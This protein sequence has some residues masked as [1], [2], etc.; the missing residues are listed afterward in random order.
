MSDDSI[1]S[2]FPL[3]FPWDT[4]DPFL[5]CVH[6][7]DFYPRGN[8]QFGPNGSLQ[9]R[10]LGQDFTIKDGW[11]M[12][13]GHKVPG[14]PVHPHRGFETVTIVR[15]GYVDHSDSLGAA[16]RYGEGDLQWLTTGHG[17]QHSEM[18]PLLHQ[19]NE[20]T[21]DLFQIWLNLPAQKKMVDPHF[22]MIWTETI[23]RYQSVDEQG[24][25]IEVIVYAGHLHDIQ[26]VDPTPE[27]WAADKNN[28]VAIWIIKLPAQST[29]VL[30][31]ATDQLNRTLYFY[32]GTEI[33]IDTQPI[34][35]QH[36][37]RLQSNKKIKIIN[38]GNDAELL[39]LQGRPINQPV[40]QYGPFVMNTQEEIHQAISDY[41]RSQFGGWPWPV[42]DPVHGDLNQGRFAKHS[43]GNL[44]KPPISNDSS[45][46]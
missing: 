30:P 38:S 31:E 5:F 39:L 14:F 33:E 45:V 18:F 42:P 35:P 4:F 43:D 24:N 23:P 1:I 16:G 15:R 28:H 44:D 36:G 22:K 12:Y 37:V 2:I 21:L 40:A 26:A 34:Q 6:H 19:E 10:N 11:R 46:T 29:W 25:N 20:N 13:H 41:R 27:S 9:G 7:Q 3:G 17:V 8:G 32:Q